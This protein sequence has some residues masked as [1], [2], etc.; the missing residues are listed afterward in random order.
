[1]PELE[2]VR[3]RLRAI[4][5]G[6]VLI[7]LAGQWVF[8]GEMGGFVKRYTFATW[9]APF[10]NAIYI[11]LLL[12][13][14]NLLLKRRLPR[15][16]FNHLELLVVY[17]MVSVASALISSD[18][19]G[20]LV[21]LMGYPAHFADSSN[22]WDKL[23]LG[24]LPSWLMV[25][26]KAALVG[27]YQGNSSFFR[28]EH[29]YAWI[30]PVLAWTVFIWALLMMMMCVNTVLRKAWVERERLT[31]PI[32]ALPLAMTE[33]AES[34]FSN[35][36]MWLGFA[37]AGG[38]TLINGFAYIYPNVPCIPIKRVDYQIASSGPFA[39]LGNVRV[40]FYF[41][42]IT[43]G[44]L[45]PVDLSFSLYF[46]YLLYK[47]EAVVVNTFG[48]PPGSGFPYT[49]SQSV[50]AYVAIFLAAVW[51]LKGHLRVVW[52]AALG[53]GD[54]KCDAAEPMSYRSAV[55]WFALS[56]MVLLVFARLAE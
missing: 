6:I 19:Q 45:M 3:I 10:Y 5:L 16:A 39:A 29:V 21:T 17:V 11:L 44:F 2:P 12:S 53:R 37:I 48:I 41:F 26:D 43:L 34:F 36:L 54:P 42:A 46:F 23:F 38:I 32:V 49:N 27:F 51:G 55:T 8:G 47:T 35:K 4:A 31:F 14:V 9:A 52:Q 7:P 20:V 50:G 33:H 40:A 24:V 25:N 56:S 22:N 28:P 15:L 1:M 13:L 18:L 30:K